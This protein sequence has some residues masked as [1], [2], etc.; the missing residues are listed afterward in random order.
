MEVSLEEVVWSHG[1]KGEQKKNLQEDYEIG[2]KR[3]EPDYGG[4]DK[5]F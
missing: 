3:W 5:S 2:A 4:A 1:G